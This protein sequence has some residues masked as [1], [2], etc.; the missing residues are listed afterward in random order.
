[1]PLP[2]TNLT[3]HFDASDTDKL[4]T[5]QGNPPSGTPSDG[6]TIGEWDDEEA[7]DIACSQTTAGEKPTY[8]TTSTGT[9]LP[10]LDFDGTNDN[11]DVGNDAQTVTKALSAMISNS[12][13][14]L[15]AAIYID[16]FLIDNDSPWL[17]DSIFADDAQYF[18]LTVRNRS[19]GQIILHNWQATPSSSDT[20][21]VL[22]ASSAKRYVVAGN[23]QGGN[24]YLAL[25]DETGLVVDGTTSSN[26]TEVLTGS[27]R[28][29]ANDSSGG[30]PY[31]GRIGEWAIYNAYNATDFT[32]ARTYFTD[33][34]VPSAGPPDTTVW[35]AFRL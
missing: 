11:L 1:M 5:T 17:C 32:N 35:T 34:W 8:R 6:S 21:V 16:A 19:G 15:F 27:F 29:G 28:V 3:G 4:F 18:G 30:R 24:L 10:S 13:Y 2:T 22:A 14:M 7:A 33:K 23:H 9:L 25:Y 12:A 20:A 31:S 26:N